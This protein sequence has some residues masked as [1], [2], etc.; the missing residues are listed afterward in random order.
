MIELINK[1]NPGKW[2][3]TGRAPLKN[4]FNNFP[5]GQLYFKILF[6]LGCFFFCCAPAR[7]RT[8]MHQGVQVGMN[9]PGL[10]TLLLCPPSPSRALSAPFPPHVRF[11]ISFEE[12]YRERHSTVVARG[13][14]QMCH[15]SGTAAR[16]TGARCCCCC[17]GAEV[18]RWPACFIHST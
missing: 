4:G 7:A 16:G 15:C 14:S 18:K 2:A 17:W 3:S 9:M 5:Q 6:S 8:N 1:M 10:A 12:K 11:V 13:G